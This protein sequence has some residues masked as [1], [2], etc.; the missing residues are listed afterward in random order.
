M[1]EQRSRPAA[2][3]EG[4]AA[5]LLAW[6]D[7]H[8][9]TLPWRAEPGM[10]ADPYAV[11][12]SEVML[13]QT[14]VAAVKSYFATFLALWPRVQDLAAAPVEDVMRRWA[15]LGYYSRA[16]NLHACARLVAER[17]GFPDTEDGLRALPGIGAYTA[18]A[19]AAIAFERPAVVVDGNVERVIVR[20]HAIAAPIKDCRPEIRV[21]AAARTP[22]ARPGDY[23]QAMMDLG[24]TICTP[25]RPACALCPLSAGCLARASG[26]QDELPVKA[27]KVER[28]E[29]LGSVFYVRRGAEVLV[30]TRPDKG[31]LGGMTEFPGSAWTAE[32]D[33]ARRGPAAG[34]ALHDGADSGGARFHAFPAAPHRLRRLRAASH[35]G[36]GRLPLGCRVRLGGRGVADA[37]AQGGDGRTAG[38]RRLRDRRAAARPPCPGTR[39][40][41]AN[42][43]QIAYWNEVAGAKWVRNQARLDRLMAPLM[44]ALLDAAAPRPGERALDV[45]CG[46]GDLALRLAGTVGR[47]GSVTAIDVS[48]P[49]LAHAAAR[50]AALA[51][52]AA[53][54]RWIEADASA[55]AFAP[56]FDLV[57]SRFGIMFFDDPPAAFANLRRALKP[58]GR[59]AFVAWRGR[60]EV[61]WMQKPLQWLAPL[62]PMPEF[63][64]GEPGPFGLA[65]GVRTRAMLE[66]AGFTDVTANRLDRAIVIGADL[67]D[68]VAMLSETGPAAGAIREASPG[69]QREAQRLLR[70][71]LAGHADAAGVVHLGAACWIYRGRA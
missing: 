23:A 15:G 47:E 11:W 20:L 65:D 38:A 36:A 63:S 3:A 26:R 28:P 32:G 70:E 64:D 30:R 8:R 56:E 61:E 13:Q 53:V 14:T 12:L 39:A 55:H 62:L 5:R 57:A 9:R 52:D 31:L 46:C 2:A 59:F 68:A 27:I 25:R 16:R 17:G 40:M 67:D 18:A 22:Q 41:T 7:R 19:V 6:Y 43:D 44:E 24:A 1:A 58:G 21:H 69:E 49:M 29:R 60:D 33:P 34:G 10:R 71:H 54:I 35:R 48:C 51:S 42:A 37:D 66:S 50:A 45:G 4:D